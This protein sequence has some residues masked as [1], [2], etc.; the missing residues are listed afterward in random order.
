MPDVP[1]RGRARC[2]SSYPT[3]TR[4]TPT[5]PAGGGA[6][7]NQ[8]RTE[9]EVCQDG[10]AL[11]PDAVAQGSEPGI[12]ATKDA[13]EGI[14]GI[15]IPYYVFL[16]M[17]GFA[18]LVDALGG[19]DIT[20]AERLPEGRRTRLRRSAGRGLG[21]R[22][23]RGRPAA[24]GRRHR[25]VVRALALHD[26]RL[27]SHE[28]PA[29]AAGRR[30]SRSS[31]RRPC[32]RASRMSRPRARTSCRPTCRSRCIPYLADLAL[33]AKEQPVQTIEL[34]P[35]RTASTSSTPTSRTSQELV[36]QALHPPTATRSRDARR[37]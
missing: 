10:N 32:S 3:A 36:R 20:V 29:R 12:E 25:A 21:D 15:E 28:A 14:L 35:E 8:L 19:V 31:R 9:V 16:D 1:V 33:K 26:E 34:T 2:R 6:G 4:V 11:Y 30:S 24:H 7:I 5:R 17:H 18:A 23:D 13:A 37:S 27:R 22:L